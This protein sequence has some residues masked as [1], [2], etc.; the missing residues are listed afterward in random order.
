MPS[1]AEYRTRSAPRK[2]SLTKRMIIMLVLI[3]L[4]LFLLIG[5][6]VMGQIMMKKAMSGMTAP[7]QT[8]TSIKVEFAE[9]SPAQD[10]IG[11]LR[12][13][14]GADLALDA[15]GIVT[16]VAIESGAEVKQGDLLLELSDDDGRA[17]VRQ[18]EA[19]AALARVTFDRA[20][21]QLDANA[22]SKADFDRA[23]ADLQ[24]R[25][26]AVAQ[27]K[28]V[29]AKKQLR[30]PFDGRAGIVTVSPG[31]YLSAGTTIVTLQQLDPVFADFF[32]P[33]GQ[34]ASLKTGQDVT[35]SLDAFPDQEFTGELSAIDPKVD[36]D[37]RNVRVEA[38]VPNPDRVLVP[39]MFAN[40]SVELGERKRYLTVPQ[41]AVTFNPYGET[42][43][44]VVPAKGKDEK[45]KDGKAQA[46][47]PTAQQVFVTTGPRRGDQ[48]AIL[49]G[50][51]E[52]VE[53]VTSGQ[54]KLKNGTPL[55]IDNKQAPPNDAHPTPQEG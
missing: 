50:I 21:R 55:I 13:V 7:P 18:L 4:L 10:A 24:A 53:I 47:L 9:W 25:Q 19:D 16:K 34:L 29:V 23:A 43:F 39:G 20:K 17:L 42:V 11:T 37:T 8:V 46:K 45:G 40:I 51:K 14:R 33:Q 22:I 2:P 44:T 15:S 28:A 32:V 38:K 1:R 26:A 27:Q 49:T 3:G 52:G 31:A 36:Q 5:W 35:L 30:A 12:A 54:L 41:T 6:N 48:V